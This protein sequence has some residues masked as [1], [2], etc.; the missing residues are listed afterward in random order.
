MG[1]HEI[2]IFWPTEETVPKPFICTFQEH[3]ADIL[4]YSMGIPLACFH[5]K[6]QGLSI[7]LITGGVW[8]LLLFHQSGNEYIRDTLEGALYRPLWVKFPQSMTSGVAFENPCYARLAFLRPP[9]WKKG[10][11]NLF[12]IICLL[13]DIITTLA[14]TMWWKHYPHGTLKY[15]PE[16]LREAKSL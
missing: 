11:S 6:C 1:N 12:S 9:P 8:S 13:A 3:L 5:A 2:C 10:V 14:N 4:S 7:S 15:L 16:G